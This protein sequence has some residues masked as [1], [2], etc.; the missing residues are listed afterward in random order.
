MADN[1]EPDITTPVVE[2]TT[3]E[4]EA[5]VDRRL[6]AWS[7]KMGYVT[8]KQMTQLLDK[9]TLTFQTTVSDLRSEFTEHIKTIR[10]DFSGEMREWRST[11]RQLDDMFRQILNQ[12]IES[13]KLSSKIE[14]QNDTIVATL[15]RFDG[16]LDDIRDDVDERVKTA[17][18]TFQA[19]IEQ[20]VK[21][22][23]EEIAELKKNDQRRADIEAHLKTIP[24]AIINMVKHP[25]TQS[26]AVRLVGGTA[27]GAVIA[28]VLRILGGG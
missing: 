10:E 20:A 3:E 27:I 23:S 21:T 22:N 24:Q 4:I 15:N 5:I 7:K 1:N 13:Q 16:R 25:L 17:L 12:N 9:Q 11:T 26:L 6:D 8:S 28:E 14:G 18:T 2:K 19:V